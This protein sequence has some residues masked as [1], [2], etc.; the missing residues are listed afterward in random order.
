MFVAY[1]RFSRFLALW[2]VSVLL[3]A[4]S[5]RDRAP[6]RVV[7]AAGGGGFQR[8]WKGDGYVYALAARDAQIVLGVGSE[9]MLLRSTDGGET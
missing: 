2:L 1:P 4:G 5:T 6:E 8:V 7:V 9:G 3:L